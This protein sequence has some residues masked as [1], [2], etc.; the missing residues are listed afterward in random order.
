MRN[1]KIYFEIFIY[2][3]IAFLCFIIIGI[4]FRKFDIFD[5]R[6]RTITQIVTEGVVVALTLFVFRCFYLIIKSKALKR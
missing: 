5:F 1:K 6:N 2:T 3:V 4:V